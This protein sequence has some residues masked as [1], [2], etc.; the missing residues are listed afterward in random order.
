MAISIL[1]GCAGSVIFPSY[2]SYTDVRVE[3]KKGSIVKFYS[4]ERYEAVRPH[5]VSL[6][7]IKWSAVNNPYNI[8]NWKHHYE[9]GESSSPEW[10][11]EKIAQITVTA[12]YEISKAAVTL[13]MQEKAGSIGGHGLVDLFRKPIQVA[14]ANQNIS[15][16]IY[17]GEVVRKEK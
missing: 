1:T 11:Y 15:G 4:K 9:L 14:F 16:Y 17:Y 12:S 8:V 6:Y 7:F 3:E 5:D 13:A 10:K 2:M